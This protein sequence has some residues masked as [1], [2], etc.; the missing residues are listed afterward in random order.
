MGVMLLELPKN[1]MT[2]P[3]SALWHIQCYGDGGSEL[4][5]HVEFSFGV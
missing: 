5:G 4:Q 3:W 1:S 2:V